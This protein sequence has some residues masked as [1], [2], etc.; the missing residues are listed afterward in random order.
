[1]A[2]VAIRPAQPADRDQLVE[3]RVLLWPESSAG[4]QLRELD[5]CLS[6]GSSSTL[7]AV[8]LV[9]LASDG[10][11]TGF[12]EAGL[13]SHADGCDPAHPVGYVE[14]WFVRE[15]HRGRLRRADRQP[16]FAARPPGAGL[17]GG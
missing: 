1:M 7:P 6:G 4:E 11:L 13:R 5:T 3:M 2:T 17:C 8:H 16:G 12:L 15:A 9:S 10:S 14:G